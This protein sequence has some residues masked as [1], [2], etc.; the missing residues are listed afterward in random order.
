MIDDWWEKIEDLCFKID[1][2]IMP[3]LPFTTPELDKQMFDFT[4]KVL[5]PDQIKVYPCAVVPW[6]IIEK[7]YNQ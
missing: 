5:L 4:Y 3:D 7:W 1:I 6:T 2:H